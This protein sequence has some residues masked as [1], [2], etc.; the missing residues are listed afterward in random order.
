MSGSKRF[1]E[2]YQIIAV[3]LIKPNPEP[4]IIKAYDLSQIVGS[5]IM[6]IGC[7]RGQTAQAGH[8]KS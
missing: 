8:F 1:K 5:P 6:E 3:L 4:A 7:P 2:G